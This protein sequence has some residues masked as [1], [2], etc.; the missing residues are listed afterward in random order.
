MKKRYE[1]PDVEVVKFEYSEHVVASSTCLNEYV[2]TDAA[3][4]DT[5]T[6]L[7]PIV[8]KYGMNNY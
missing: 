4:K 7:N 3:G 2:N 8:H 6:C 1:T 5:G